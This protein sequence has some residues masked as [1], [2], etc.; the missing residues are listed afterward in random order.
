MASPSREEDYDYTEGASAI[1]IQDAVRSSQ[2]ARRDSRYGEDGVGS[3]FDGPSHSVIPSSV[4]RMSLHEHGRRSSE[5]WVRRSLSRRRSEDSRSRGGSRSRRG[6]GDGYVSYG[7]IDHGAEEYASDNDDREEAGPSR[8]ARSRASPIIPSRPITV[9]ENIANMFGR[10]PQVSDSPPHS[11]RPSLSSRTSRSGLLRRYSSRRSDA[12]SDYAIES[13]ADGDE[14]WGYAS[15]EEDEEDYESDVGLRDVDNDSID[16]RSF[17]ERSF[18]PSPGPTL[19]L[20]AGDPIFG[21]EERIDMG[22]L[23]PLDPP[24]PGPPSRQTIYISDEDA[25]I[26]FVGYETLPIRQFFWRALCVLS[27]GILGLL[28]HWFPRLWLRWVTQEKAFKDLKHGFVVVEV[29]AAL[30]LIIT[31]HDGM[32]VCLQRYC[33][34]PCHRYPLSIP[35]IDCIHV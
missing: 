3:M 16:M 5:G 10:A 19:P 13:E 33:V 9:F 8:E 21:G 28:G 2:R 35:Y 23:E 4:S 15:E 22:E 24:P 20:M 7:S 1:D 6:S 31:I 12:G 18:P 14:R 29:G 27:F 32:E 11:R 26:R 30:F 17:D 34:I 25:N